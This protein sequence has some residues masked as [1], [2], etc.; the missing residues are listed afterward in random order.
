MQQGIEAD[1]PDTVIASSVCEGNK[2]MPAELGKVSGP[3]R[4]GVKVQRA[5]AP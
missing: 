1:L 3:N 2:L 5:S 4:P